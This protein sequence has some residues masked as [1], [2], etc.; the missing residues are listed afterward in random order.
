MLLD[1]LALN[2]VVQGCFGFNEGG[3]SAPESGVLLS[4]IS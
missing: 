1:W 4:I 2:W 3:D